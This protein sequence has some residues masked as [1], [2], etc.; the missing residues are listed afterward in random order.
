MWLTTLLKSRES[1]GFAAASSMPRCSINPS[2]SSPDTFHHG[3]GGGEASALVAAALGAASL[4]MACTQSKESRDR[5]HT[6]GP[7]EK[8]VGLGA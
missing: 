1:P 8:H 3:G 2:Q 7:G 4:Q 6:G 5:S